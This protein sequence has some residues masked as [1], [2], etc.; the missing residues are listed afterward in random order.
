MGIVLNTCLWI[1]RS[2]VAHNYFR[3]KYFCE[4]DKPGTVKA[5][6]VDN[7]LNDCHYL[8]IYGETEVGGWRVETCPPY[9]PKPLIPD[10]KIPK[11]H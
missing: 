9:S 10:L 2:L 3:R 6:S 7:D 1:R 4:G 5:L 8:P 11:F